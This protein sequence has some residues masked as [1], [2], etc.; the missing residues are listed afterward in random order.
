MLAI[1]LV[2]AFASST[3]LLQPTFTTVAEGQASSIEEPKEIVVQTAAEWK[4]LWQQHSPGQKLPVVD[5]AKSTVAAVFLGTRNTGGHRVL[6]TA[7]NREGPDTVV[8]WNEEQPGAGLMVT[9]ALTAPFHIVRFDKATGVV[10]FK[11]GPTT[12]AK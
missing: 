3:G 12:N 9:Q 10:K 11:K 1:M 7:V 8:T 2:L 4:V 5:F 6:V